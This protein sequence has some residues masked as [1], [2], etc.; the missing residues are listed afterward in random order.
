MTWDVEFTDKFGAWFDALTEGEQDAVAA[1]VG[2]LEALGVSLDYPHSSGIRTSRHPHLRE[3][4][5]QY[6]GAPY[7]VLY[8]FD[9]RRIGLLLLGGGKTGDDRWYERMVPIADDLYDRHLEALKLAGG[10][11]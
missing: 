9:P 2:L 1:K 4:R 6:A 7:R 5:V 8:A 10:S 11:T 3:L